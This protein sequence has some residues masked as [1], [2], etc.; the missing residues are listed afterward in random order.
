MDET[1]R[2][3]VEPFPD[4]RKAGASTRAAFRRKALPVVVL[5]VT[6]AFAFPVLNM[7][8]GLRQHPQL[9]IAVCV[10]YLGVLKLCEVIFDGFNR[11][12]GEGARGEEKL[13]AALAELE[14]R[15]WTVLHDVVLDSWNIDHVAI[16]PTGVFTIETKSHRGR[17][18]HDGQQLLRSGHPLEK[19]FLRQAKSQ[20]LWLG[21]Q[22]EQRGHNVFVTP[23]VC[24][25]RAYVRVPKSATRPVVVVPLKWLLETLERGKVRL[26][27]AALRDV[28]AA[29]RECCA[30][31]ATRADET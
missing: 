26:N 16:G 5:I 4:M 29:V 24:F 27:E 31:V 2:L 7:S 15:G 9:S 10:A 20:G 14:T 1:E 28:T 13:G 30:H 22:L 6:I 17:I 19:D 11:T 23:I 21:K 25:T 8:K 18:Q 12:W 3:P